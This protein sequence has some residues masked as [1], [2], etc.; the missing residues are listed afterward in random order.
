MRTWLDV[1]RMITVLAVLY[2]TF[3][4]VIHILSA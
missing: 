3:I 2:F 1:A 4:A